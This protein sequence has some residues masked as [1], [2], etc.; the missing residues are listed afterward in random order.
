MRSRRVL[1]PALALLLVL[2]VVSAAAQQAPASPPKAAAKAVIINGKTLSNA[3]IKSLAAAV[4]GPV[5]PGSY[6]YDKVS[7]A[8]GLQGGPLAGLIPAGLNVGGPL[9][10]DAS[11]GNTGV[12]INGRELTVVN[13]LRLQQWIGTPVMQGRFWVDAQGNFGYE[14]GPL[15]GN[16]AVL[17]QQS[18]SRYGQ[19]GNTTTECNG[20]GCSSGN[21]A[22]GM[23]VITDGQGG[24]AVFT[25]DGKV[26]TPP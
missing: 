12:F 1:F 7:G 2:D 6:W 20:G 15:M 14:G 24:A 11:N 26:I 25:G 3:Q 18:G 9:A 23:G 22:T 10:E 5:Q 21:S 16:L 8:W 17:A 13:V 4:H 19:Q